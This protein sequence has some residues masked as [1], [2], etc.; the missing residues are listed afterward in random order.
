MH[1]K[2]KISLSVDEEVYHAIETT[3][4]NRNMAMSHVAQK[5][6]ELWLKRETEA[7]MAQ[8]YEEMANEDLAFS[9]T[10]LDGQR[11]VLS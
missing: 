3:A 10:A 7:L 8:G 1:T 5:A 2:R 11:E 9:E 6:L 4:K